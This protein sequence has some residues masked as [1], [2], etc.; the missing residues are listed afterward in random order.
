MTSLTNLRTAIAGRAK[1]TNELAVREGRQGTANKWRQERTAYWLERHKRDGD[2]GSL[3]KYRQSRS[4]GRRSRRT[5]AAM[6]EKTKASRAKLRY[7]RRLLRRRQAAFQPW[8]WKAGNITPAAKK[9][10][11]RA[12]NAGLYVT[13]TTGG[14]HAP[15]PTTTPSR[16]AGLSTSPAHGWERFDGVSPNAYASD[17][18][19]IT[20]QID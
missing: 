17:H 2:E 13:S 9:F 7:W 6:R 8:M 15:T 11:V 18:C 20:L 10:V 16:S 1:R 3:R 19:P 4:L 14:K 12:V 5:L